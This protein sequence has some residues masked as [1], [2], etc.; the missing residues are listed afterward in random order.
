MD[1]EAEESRSINRL[2]QSSPKIVGETVKKDRFGRNFRIT[3]ALVVHYTI[4]D[5]YSK[6]FPVITEADLHQR[7]MLALIEEKRELDA[8]FLGKGIALCHRLLKEKDK[9]QNPVWA[10]KANNISNAL[11]KKYDDKRA[12][13]FS[14][15]DPFGCY[16]VKDEELSHLVLESEDFRYRVNVPIPLRYEGLFK[17]RFGARKENQ[18]VIW[19][20]V[21]F[22]EFIQK[23]DLALEDELAENILLQEAGHL[24]KSPRK[25]IFSLGA[26]FD[27]APPPYNEKTYFKFWDIQRGLQGTIFREKKFDRIKE[28]EDYLSR[29]EHT[30]EVGKK[31]IFFMREA[32]FY[33][34]PLGY[35]L[36]LSYPELEKEK[37]EKYWNL[38]RRSFFSKEY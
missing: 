22:T 13:V 14:Q 10:E 2:L 35:F 21:R 33:K 11:L 31:E 19:N 12:E 38:I 1:S 24:Q 28:K 23:E 5:S 6:E 37:A 25:I 17:K 27:K 18:S 15:T 34:R 4:D 32:Y 16:E 8:L 20:L 30:N 7:E 3:P 26:T 9:N 36:S 29:W